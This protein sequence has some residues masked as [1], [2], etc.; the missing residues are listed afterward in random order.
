MVLRPAAR[1]RARDPASRSVF[2]SG[3]ELPALCAVSRSG[4]DIEVLRLPRLV[5]RKSLVV[6]HHESAETRYTLFETIRAFAEERLAEADERSR[7]RDRHAAYFAE[8]GRSDGGSGGTAPTGEIRSTGCETELAN[9]RSAFRWSLERGQVA[10]ATDIAAHAALMGFSVELFET[11]SWAEALLDREQADVRRLPAAVRRSGLRLLRRARRGGDRERPSRHRAGGPT[12]LR[13]L[14][15]R[16]RDVHR[17]AG[18]GLLRQPGSLR[19]ADPRGRGAARHQ[20]G[21]RDRGVRRRAAVVRPGR[22]GAGADRART[23]SRRASSATPTGS[24]TR[25]GSSAWPARRWTRSALSRPGTRPWPTSLSTTSGSSR[26]SWLATRRSCTP[27]TV[28]SRRP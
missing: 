24:P 27:R 23:R 22:R 21:L 20:P 26:A 13:V 18:A 28:S 6:A 19:R 5:G 11:I 3:F 25:C 8:R 14:R 15:A 9:L 16:L 7:P 12:R 17:G 2:A 1:R 10:R 4:D